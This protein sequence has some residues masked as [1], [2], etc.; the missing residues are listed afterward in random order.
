M[1]LDVLIY[2]HKLIRQNISVPIYLLYFF[3]FFAAIIQ[4]FGTISVIP[5]VTSLIT[6]EIIKEKV[7]EHNLFF[8]KEID[9]DNLRYISGFFFILITFLLQISVFINGLLSHYI[10]QKI[11]FNLRKKYFKNLL[12]NKLKYFSSNSVS[13]VSNLLTSEIRKIGI[14]IRSFLVVIYSTLTLTVICLG[15]F[16][17]NPISLLSILLIIVIFYL[18]FIFSKQKLR[19][20]SY[21]KF[22]NN[23]K[24]IQV[25]N[26][27]FFGFRDIL[28]LN[29]KNKILDTYNKIISNTLKITTIE[30]SLLAIP[31]HF[32]EI[33]L[34]T[35]IV[36]Y[37]LTLPSGTIDIN[38]LPIYA[39][40]VLALWRVLPSI[41]NLYRSFSEIQVNISSFENLRKLNKKFLIKSETVKNKIKYFKK[42]IQ[43]KNIKFQYPENIKIFSYNFK[44]KKKE[45]ILIL[46]KS[47]SGKSTLL[48][49][50]SFLKTPNS[51]TIIIDGKDY[52]QDVLGYSRLI[53]YVT[54]FNYY[55]QG[56]IAE[57]ISFLKRYKSNDINKL[58]KIYEICG[59]MNFLHN[60]DNIFNKKIK[61]SAYEL[62]G[63]QKQRLSLARALF[64]NPQILI[65]DE[66]L[67]ALD[68]FS[69][70]TILEK[71]IQHYPNLTLIYVSHRTNLKFFTKT[72]KLSQ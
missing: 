28:V 31:K 22:K 49:I 26:S 60:F 23:K 2:C 56:T 59:L 69:E 66:G 61:E 43:I 47:G 13:D 52:K 72:I 6:P 48:D 53:S 30:L 46:G 35:L 34:F 10:S 40:Y 39:F 7:T 71:V 58:K 44:I 18:L 42:E 50:I 9:V 8:L 68:N 1:L 21:K 55:F 5:L 19:K 64:R 45:K 36:L 17:V 27:I 25:Q 16:L 15:I 37:F 32:M 11:V 62:S 20:Y 54:Q 29:L 67:N 57:N 24:I 38:L 12:N 4:L 33:L 63:G 3:I 70:K 14:L 65:I 41:F 51:G